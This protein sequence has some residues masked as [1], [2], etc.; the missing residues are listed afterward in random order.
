MAPLW[1]H[2]LVSTHFLALS[3]AYQR[4]VFWLPA[5]SCCLIGPLSNGRTHGLLFGNGVSGV[6]HVEWMW[7]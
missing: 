2:L 3:Y 7:E 5:S 6:C 4:P 1:R